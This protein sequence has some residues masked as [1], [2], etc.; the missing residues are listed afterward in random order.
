MKPKKIVKTVG[1]FGTVTT[2]YWSCGVCEKAHRT[3]KA[4]EKCIAKQN[5]PPKTT[6][7]WTHENLAK[8][9]A[10]RD[11]GLTFK[12]CGKEFH[13]APQNARMMYL[14]ALWTSNKGKGHTTFKD[15][16]DIGKI[17]IIDMDMSIR[18]ANCLR[19]AGIENI[20][21]LCQRSEKDL[22]KGKNFGRKSLNEINEKLSDLGVALKQ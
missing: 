21:E 11:S 2:E 13:I 9:K 17:K 6:N 15:L 1:R 19:N 10:L 18:S 22:L 20:D 7:K 4:A 12:A 3:E 8:I 5:K 14:R 16:G